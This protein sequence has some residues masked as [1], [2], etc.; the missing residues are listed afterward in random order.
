[1]VQAMDRIVR[2]AEAE[3]WSGNFA[4]LRAGSATSAIARST[5][6]LSGELRAGAIVVFSAVP[7]VAAAISAARPLAPIVAVAPTARACGRIGL[8]WGVVPQ[9]AEVG[10]DEQPGVAKR[11][12]ADLGLAAPGLPILAVMSN[13]DV[14]S[15]SVLAA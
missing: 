7:G 15:V 4:A 5:A 10:Y 11:L 8:L 12:V 9:V 6:Q 3:L 1:V 14:V 13:D 2:Q